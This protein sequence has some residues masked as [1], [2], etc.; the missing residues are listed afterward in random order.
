MKNKDL[1]NCVK[2]NLNK[3]V[4]LLFLCL[5]LGIGSCLMFVSKINHQKLIKKEISA[6]KRVKTM[7]DNP[8]QKAVEKKTFEPVFS[9]S[10]CKFSALSE[11]VIK[12]LDRASC[13]RISQYVIVDKNHVYKQLYDP[14]SLSSGPY[15]IIMEADIKSFRSLGNGY[16][17]DSSHL[18][19]DAGNDY[20]IIKDVDVGSVQ[21]LSTHYLKDN[22]NIYFVKAYGSDYRQ[23][24]L[25]GFDVKTFTINQ[26]HDNFE[27]Y[28]K[29]KNGV[30]FE[31]QPFGELNSNNS[32]II[33]AD[34]QSFELLGEY[35]LA[36]DKNH[37]YYGGKM[38]EY[39][40][41]PSFEILPRGYYR[42]A[43]GIYTNPHNNGF[44]LIAGSDSC[45]FELVDDKGDY[46][47]SGYAKDKN[48][49]YYR[50]LIVEGADSK[51]FQT[52]V[53]DGIYGTYR[54]G[55]D[56]DY[57]YEGQFRIGSLPKLR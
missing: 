7:C 10:D 47:W 35:L 49:V 17:K 16:Y 2:S 31:E 28:I 19:F 46:D 21:V 15:V 56:K 13:N 34:I 40:D 4:I 25:R 48:H 53:I 33:G 50:D 30:Y 51:S 44:K 24:I 3:I 23:T 29:D 1:Y 36:K 6:I 38:F 22:N 41:A 11:I 54:R 26:N 27:Q 55:F 18:Y 20:K 12:E 52:K 39:L 9:E 14:G 43:Y 37:V 5:L 42:D 8:K 32:R 57:E 45:T